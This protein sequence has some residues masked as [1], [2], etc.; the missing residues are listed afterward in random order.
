MIKVIYFTWRVIV[1]LLQIERS[2]ESTMCAYYIFSK[3]LYFSFQCVCI[4]YKE[5]SL[6]KI[7]PFIYIFAGVYFSK[8]NTPPSRRYKSYY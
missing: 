1:T 8:D 2:D 3:G 6:V 7:W 5:I 4:H